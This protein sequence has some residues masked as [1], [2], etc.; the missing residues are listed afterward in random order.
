MKLRLTKSAGF[1]DRVHPGRAFSL[2]EVLISLSVGAVLIAM[3]MSGIGKVRNRAAEAACIGKLRQMAVAY[4]MYVQDHNGRTPP[5][6]VNASD[7]ESEGHSFFGILLLRN[8]YGDS[9]IWSGK[10]TMYEPM[11]ICPSVRLNKLTTKPGKGPDYG[12]SDKMSEQSIAYY[13]KPSKTPMIWDDWVGNWIS[14]RTMPLRHEGINAAFL[15]GHVE[16]IKQKDGR[17]YSSWWWAAVTRSEPDD[18]LLG[19]GSP[20]GST[21][22][23]TN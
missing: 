20:L 17:L 22:V 6:I 9:Q 16:N 4:T 1:A 14:G 3:L 15:D 10:S 7:E 11:E 21:Q 23:P 12:F 5:T 19:K 8:Y 13:T 18:S 2:I